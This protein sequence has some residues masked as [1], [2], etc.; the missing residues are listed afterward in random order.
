MSR[1]STHH[2]MSVIHSEDVQFKLAIKNKQSESYLECD[3]LESVELLSENATSPSIQTS[4]P[5][6][7]P[8]IASLIN[9][10]MKELINLKF[11]DQVKENMYWHVTQLLSNQHFDGPISFTG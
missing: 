6:C 4:C 3:I 11:N 1:G 8:S 7:S 5:D 9:N 2:G 10:Q